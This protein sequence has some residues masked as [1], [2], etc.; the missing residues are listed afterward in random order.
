MSLK[1]SHC[2]CPWCG[3][4][5]RHFLDFD[6]PPVDTIYCGNCGRYFRAEDA[7]RPSTSSSWMALVR[8]DEISIVRENNYHGRISHGWFGPDKVLVAAT[9][10]YGFKGRSPCYDK[11]VRLAGELAREFNAK[12]ARDA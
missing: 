5:G 2:H 6:K 1:E 3:D 4:L 9:A 7:V 11:I 8:N 12:E 10:I